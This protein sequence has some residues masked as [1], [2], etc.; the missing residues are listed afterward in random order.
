MKQI[1][2]YIGC[3]GSYE[4][5]SLAQDKNK[6]RTLHQTSLKT[7]DYNIFLRVNNM[8]YYT[9]CSN[10]YIPHNSLPNV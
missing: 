1:I 5:K 6:W 9:Y 2:D 3:S 4:M 10:Y 8:S 7:V